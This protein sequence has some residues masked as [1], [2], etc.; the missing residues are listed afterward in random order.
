MS[1]TEEMDVL[2]TT[3]FSF[4]PSQPGPQAVVTRGRMLRLVCGPPV[5][6]QTPCLQDG[7][8]TGFGLGVGQQSSQPES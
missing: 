2:L 7:Q 6:C 5:F 1:R 3:Q 8:W 4:L